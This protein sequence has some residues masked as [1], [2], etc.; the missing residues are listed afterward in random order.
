MPNNQ[1][2]NIAGVLLKYFEG[3]NLK[4]KKWFKYLLYALVPII[5][6]IGFAGYWFMYRKDKTIIETNSTDNET[7]KGSDSKLEVTIQAVEV[8]HKTDESNHSRWH[9]YKDLKDTVDKWVR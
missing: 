6:L 2:T 7:P 8:F 9:S 4:Y 1:D 5:F 3:T